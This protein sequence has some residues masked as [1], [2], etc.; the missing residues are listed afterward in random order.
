MDMKLEYGVIGG[1]V[2]LIDEISGGSFRLWPYRSEAP[3][4][5]QPNVLDELA[6]EERLDKDTYRMGEAAD[7][8]LS[9]FR[10]ISAITAGFK[11]L[12]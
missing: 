1:E 3:Q 10:A 12:P 5:N 8:V 7:S 11:D 4:L 9:K 2:H 6:P